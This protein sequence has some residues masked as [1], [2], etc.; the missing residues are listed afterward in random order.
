LQERD[1]S[2]SKIS[3]NGSIKLECGSI[4]EKSGTIATNFRLL[5]L[6]I[7]AKI[8]KF[9]MFILKKEG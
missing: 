2:C 3:L 5:Q 8:D 7:I 4:G 6:V 1:K 9:T